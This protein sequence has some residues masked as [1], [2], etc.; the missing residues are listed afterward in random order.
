MILW[1]VKILKLENL[2]I[3]SL[4]VEMKRTV[5]IWYLDVGFREVQQVQHC[6]EILEIL[7]PYFGSSW[8]IWN[9]N[10]Q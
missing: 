9:R 1:F 8:I 2:H 10:L 3:K 7:C 4:T 6:A 5:F